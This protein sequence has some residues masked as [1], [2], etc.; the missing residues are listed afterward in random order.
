MTEFTS[1]I[2]TLFYSQS[3][4]YEILSNMVNLKKIKDKIPNDKI[5]DIVFDEN[6]FSFFMNSTWEVKIS[7][8]ERIP[9]KI[10]KFSTNQTPI[11][12]NMWIQLVSKAKNETKMKLTV[13][14]N[15]NSFLKPILSS[16]LQEGIN[17][18]ANI[19]TTIPYNEIVE[20]KY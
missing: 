14:A 20:K 7:I 6:S 13:K 19:L 11:E 18:I 10:I 15:L 1:D 12:A 2:K 4:V 3:Q 16:S 8:I 5:Q 17:K 9:P